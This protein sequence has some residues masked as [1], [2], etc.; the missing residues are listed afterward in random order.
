MENKK[1]Q[2]QMYLDNILLFSVQ[3]VSALSTS[4]RQALI[5][6]CEERIFAYNTLL[7]NV[8]QRDVSPTHS[9]DISE[10]HSGC[11]MKINKQNK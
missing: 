11:I 6:T 7:L 5:K 3:H 1:H 9:F 10:N 2:S 8:P 4:H